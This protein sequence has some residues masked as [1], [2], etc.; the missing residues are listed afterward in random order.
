[1]AVNAQAIA[2]GSTSRRPSN[3][4]DDNGRI[5]IALCNR[6]ATL[7]EILQMLPLTPHG[8]NPGTKEID[9]REAAS[10]PETRLVDRD[11]ITTRWAKDA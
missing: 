2:N 11:Q 3:S 6:E 7:C 10:S 4:L 8:A 9:R 5:P 1:M